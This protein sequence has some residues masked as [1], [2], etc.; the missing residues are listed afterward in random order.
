MPRFAANISMLF[1]ELPVPQRVAAAAAA[2][3]RAVEIQFPYAEDVGALQRQL[4][5]TSL[6][7]VL[8]NLPAGNWAAGDR[9]IACDPGRVAEFRT[10]VTLAI[11]HALRLRCRQ[12]NCLAGVLPHGVSREFAW[13]TLVE[14]LGY[15]ATILAAAG[16]RLMLEPVNVHDVPGFF[17]SRSAEFEALRREVGNPNLHLQYDCYHMQL[18]EGDLGH[19]IERLLPLIG[20]VQVADVPGRHEPGTGEINYAHVFALLDQLGY[21]GWIGCEYRPATTTAAGLG[22]LARTGN[23]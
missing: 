10:G 5:A 12:V 3:F 2:G 8:V 6:E 23:P 4:E 22:W 9:G 15:A 7:M 1:T 14:N 16:L 20:H 13:A 19:T 18:M 21:E 17:I 11:D